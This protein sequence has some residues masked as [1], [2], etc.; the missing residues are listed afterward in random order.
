MPIGWLLLRLKHAFMQKPKKNIAVCVGHSRKGDNGAVNT[1]GVNEWAF[2]KPIAD[3]VVKLLKSKGHFAYIVDVYGGNSYGSAMT[4]VAKQ[5]RSLNADVAIELH[6]NSAELTANGNEFLYWHS[7]PKSKDLAEALETAFHRK[8]PRSKNRGCKA[9]TPNDRGGGFLQKTHC[10]A[11][12]CEPFFGSNEAET[13]FFTAHSDQ[14][15]E[16]YADGI[17]EWI[18]IHTA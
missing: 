17:V 7:S 2:N 5:L 11:V 12:I 14:I 3:G 9:I 15:A 13:E 6:F 8:F 18:A 1:N 10:P 4:D 16:S